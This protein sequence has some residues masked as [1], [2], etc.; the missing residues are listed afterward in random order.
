MATQATLPTLPKNDSP[1]TTCA[2]QQSHG[3]LLQ[4]ILSLQQDFRCEQQRREEVDNSIAC[5]LEELIRV[6]HERQGG[7]MTYEEKAF[8]LPL[9][10]L[11][12]G[13]SSQAKDSQSASVD[14]SY[15]ADT[16][17]HKELATTAWYSDLA[18]DIGKPPLLAGVPK[19]TSSKPLIKPSS[20][21]E[22]TSADTASL[23]AVDHRPRSNTLSSN[24]SSGT[25]EVH[26]SFSEASFEIP[27][28]ETP[29]NGATSVLERTLEASNEA[30]SKEKSKRSSLSQSDQVTLTQSQHDTSTVEVV[31]TPASGASRKGER[32]TQFEDDFIGKTV[33]KLCGN[34]MSCGKALK[35]VTALLE[36]KGHQRSAGA[37]TVHWYTKLQDSYPIQPAKTTTKVDE[38]NEVT[39]AREKL[40]W[41]VKETTKVILQDRRPALI[42]WARRPITKIQTIQTHKGDY[43]VN[44]HPANRYWLFA[45]VTLSAPRGL[46]EARSQ[47]FKH[48]QDVDLW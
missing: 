17:H 12:Q 28:P 43:S 24:G 19:A 29:Q 10:T 11:P 21:G 25:S 37:V 8:S 33:Q 35:Q 3:S 9:A 34:G 20:Y 36:E 22:S 30:L 15:S 41:S 27:P 38:S 13:N 14:D 45:W 32:Y 18:Q 5:R 4:V 31:S 42:D 39:N 2:Q 48:M 46:R 44:T 1:D 23:E 7:L 47:H 26:S 40:L 6:V 16:S